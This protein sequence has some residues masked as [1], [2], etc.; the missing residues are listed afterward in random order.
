[1]LNNMMGGMP[2]MSWG[3]QKYKNMKIDYTRKEA[4]DKNKSI[5]L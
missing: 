4:A 2:P 1:M 3:P 5:K